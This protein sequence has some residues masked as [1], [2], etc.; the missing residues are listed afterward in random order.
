MLNYSLT[1]Q[2]AYEDEFDISHY[3]SGLSAF[4]MEC[5][6]PITIAIQG[7]WGSGKTSV[8][9]MVRKD[10]ERQNAAY[11]VWVNTWQFSQ[12]NKDTNLSLS[13]MEAILDE[14][15][16]KEEDAAQNIWQDIGHI[17]MG[18][19]KRAAIAAMD[20]TIGSSNT[21][22]LQDAIAGAAREIKAE[23]EVIKNLKGS[24][25]QCVAAA[26]DKSGLDRIVV[27]IDDLDRLEP[28]RAVELLEVLKLFLDCEQCVFVLAIDYDVV[29]SG[30]SSK[31][32][33]AVD[34]DKGKRFFDKIIQVPFKMPV[35]QYNISGF[36]KKT[37]AAVADIEC[38]YEEIENYLSLIEN[39]I[40]S[41]PRSIKRLFNSFLLLL[42]IVDAE[43]IE[44]RNDNKKILFAMLCMQLSYDKLYNYVVSNRDT[45]DLKFF[46]HL[47]TDDVND[48]LP[49]LIQENIETDLDKAREIQEFIRD[50]N[51]TFSPAA[52]GDRIYK[53]DWGRA[54]TL[55]QSSSVTTTENTASGAKTRAAFTYNGDTY[56]TRGA[57]KM[58]LSNLALHLI[59][60]Y[61]KENRPDA[62]AFMDKVNQAI[63]YYWTDQKKAGLY[64]IVES[65]DPRL[66]EKDNSNREWVFWYFTDEGETVRLGGKELTVSKGWGASEIIK[67][68]GVL[69]YNDKITSNLD[70]ELHM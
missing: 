30:V 47:A 36:V 28:L 19:A 4:M 59:L 24:F 43:L 32:G 38:D 9:Q 46:E 51:V 40:G 50:F 63:P 66:R 8:M 17:S 57:N 29:V 21:K 68:I 56:M 65:D 69:D 39:S 64:Q 25:Q 44:D 10:L 67:L 42:K 70:F 5:E 41:N 49:V 61:V 33:N 53:R 12:F 54:R 2:A 20:F 37:L 31:Y 11:C 60:D 16:I 34:E 62:D 15:D 14:F 48:V 58:N 52:G 1:D 55:L 26:A 13:L 23:N 7:D 27:F 18:V 45:I 35:A 22:D 3:I 6:T